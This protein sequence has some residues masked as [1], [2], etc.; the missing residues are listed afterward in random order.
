MSLIDRMVASVPSAPSLCGIGMLLIFSQCVL[1]AV[2]DD[3][4]SVECS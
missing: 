3:I 2:G 1:R 4:L